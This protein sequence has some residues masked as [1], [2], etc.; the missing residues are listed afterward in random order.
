MA[1]DWNFVA[2]EMMRKAFHLS[3]LVIP[4]VYYFFVSREYALLAMGVIVLI[5]G[6]IEVLRLR[7]HQLY[8]TQLMRDSETKG[9]M[10]GAYFYAL[11]AMLISILIFSKTVACA[12][13]LFLVLGD[14]ITGIA[15][16]VYYTLKKE[17]PV[18]IVRKP[19]SYRLIPGILADLSFAIRHYKPPVLMLVMFI[20]CSATGLL[21]TPQL[22]YL[23]IV[24]GALGAV[25][26]DSFPWRIRGFV[27]DDNL[28]IP[29]V[30]GALMTLAM[31]I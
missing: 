28:S 29:L 16:A 31:I 25:V 9:R 14:A 8:D 10:I 2:K 30:A 19:D 24:A 26:A 22:S 21:F 18:N 12:A 20:V 1:S 15:G 11:F 17:K 5:A 4:V 7:G 27:I 13:M 3:G 23:A 6:I